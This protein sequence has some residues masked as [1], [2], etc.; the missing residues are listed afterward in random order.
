MKI[1][2]SLSEFSLKPLEDSH[3]P[4]IW[5]NKMI[6]HILQDS[7]IISLWS[8]MIDQVQTIKKESWKEKSK[9]NEK[10]SRIQLKSL[11]KEEE[12]RAW[13]DMSDGSE[14]EGQQSNIWVWALN[15]QH[16]HHDD[17]GDPRKYNTAD[18]L[19]RIDTTIHFYDTGK[20]CSTTMTHP[21]QGHNPIKT[22][23]PH[24]WNEID[25]PQIYLGPKSQAI[26]RERER[27][28]PITK[29]NRLRNINFDPEIGS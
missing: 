16:V 21:G 22:T 9:R 4:T 25:S 18:L 6:L 10:S 3:C 29:Q 13:K 11:E 17:T 7:E 20:S 14:R 23:R 27:G 12:K 5:R 28:V 19:H 26:K 1:C 2:I 8:C 15:I 24:V